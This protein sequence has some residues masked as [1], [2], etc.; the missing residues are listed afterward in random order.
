MAQA[1]LA[2]Y[3]AGC[4]LAVTFASIQ[5]CSWKYL[6]LMAA[7]TLGI[8]FLSLLLLVREPGWSDDA[9][10]LPG[11]IGLGVA[12]VLASAWLVVNAA[13]GENVRKSQRVWPAAAGVVA[14]CAAVFLVLRP[15]PML[16]ASTNGAESATL[17]APGMSSPAGAAPVTPRVTG[18][19][20]IQSAALVGTTVLGALLLGLVT[21]S[22][23]LGHRYLTDTDMPIAPL[24]RFTKLYVA[25]V[26]ARIVWVAVASAPMLASSF[27]P[28][29]D[30][31]WFWVV[32]TV[33][34][35][36]GLGATAVFAYMVWDCVR[37]R[38]TQSATALF[39]LSMVFVFLGELAGQYLVR[40]ESLA[41]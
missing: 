18:R 21:A 34:V 28:T 39:Y 33:R 5:S 13:Q 37:R 40:T 6:R 14:M 38:A 26:V 7:V 17:S 20:G 16:A 15:D 4:F 35:G 3:A 32:V 31:T 23:L 30:Y 24:R 27:Q 12:V 10:R 29:S 1:F 19:S 2:Q 8:T 11:V 9:Y 25:A 22:M 41:V 36:V